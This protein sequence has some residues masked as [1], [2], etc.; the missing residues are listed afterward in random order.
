MV[1]SASSTEVHSPS[2]EARARRDCYLKIDVQ[3]E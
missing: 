2:R 1:F 3:E